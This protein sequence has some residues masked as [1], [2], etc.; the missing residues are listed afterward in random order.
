MQIREASTTPATA[1]PPATATV[2]IRVLRL[3]SEPE[4][5]HTI[6]SVASASAP[7]SSQS[8]IDWSVA[9]GRDQT[10]AECGVAHA[11]QPH[12]DRG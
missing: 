1:D 2:P 8:T 6:P 9:D 10:T 7:A 11:Q 5:A 12:R 3:S 4:A